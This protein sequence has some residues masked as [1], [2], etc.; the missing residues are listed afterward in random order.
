M[1]VFVSNVKENYED[2]QKHC[3]AIG[4]KLFEPKSASDENVLTILLDFESRYFIGVEDQIEEGRYINYLK[5][6]F[7]GVS[8]T[9]L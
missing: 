6:S 8:V 9:L 5:I 2:A 3:N 7:F 4:G 1:E